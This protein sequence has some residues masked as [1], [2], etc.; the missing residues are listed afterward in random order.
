M[1]IAYVIG[2]TVPPQLHVQLSTVDV[3]ADSLRETVA[4]NFAFAD[5]AVYR[6]AA[7]EALDST[8]FKTSC[9]LDSD[10]FVEAR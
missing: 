2:H 9:L 8:R 10:S 4:R 3:M 5:L 7:V 6:D 1:S